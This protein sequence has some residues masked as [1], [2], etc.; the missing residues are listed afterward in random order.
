[1]PSTA[2]R[3]LAPGDRRRQILTAAHGLLE[4]HSIEEI[5][6]ETVAAQLGVS[7]GLLFHYFGT[8]RDFRGAVIQAAATELLGQLRP[9]PALS[10]AAQLHAALD[11]FTQTVACRP[12]LFLAVVRYNTELS[13]LHWNVRA[14]LAGWLTTGLARAGMP[15]TPAVT[16]TISGWLAFTEEAILN[17]ISAPAQPAEPAAPAP[18]LTRTDLVNLCEQACYRLLEL[19]VADPARW[20]DIEQAITRPR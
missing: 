2:A 16:A 6:V 13:S 20:P 1:M 12:R 4:T 11:T 8:Q 15:I 5:S 3:R 17:W 18:A 7:P 14:V 19:A 10:P 9:D